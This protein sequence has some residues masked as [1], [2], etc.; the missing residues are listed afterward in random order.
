[1]K[2]LIICFFIFERFLS[3]TITKVSLNNKTCPNKLKID[4]IYESLCPESIRFLK[5]TLEKT[6]QI[7]DYDRYVNIQLW[8]YG[9]AYQLKSK[10]TGKW[11]FRC[12]HGPNECYG[13]IVQ[14]CGKYYLNQ[15]DFLHFA[16]CIATNIEVNEN[17]FN[18]KVNIQ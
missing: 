9:N 10:Y 17:D 1:M 15:D 6:I 7:K 5:E 12:Q 18:S 13:N 11:L 2:M 4:V 14:T 8:P 16:V 3:K